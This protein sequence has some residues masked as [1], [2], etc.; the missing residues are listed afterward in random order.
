M[1]ARG[2]TNFVVHVP[3]TYDAHV[4]FH[5]V[6]LV[7]R[8]EKDDEIHAY[9]HKQAGSAGGL[10]EDLTATPRVLP[11][12]NKPKDK[13][14]EEEQER[15]DREVQKVKPG[16]ET[17][18]GLARDVIDRS[19]ERDTHKTGLRRDDRMASDERRSEKEEREQEDAKDSGTPSLER[20]A[21]SESHL[22][23]MKPAL[24]ASATPGVRDTALLQQMPLTA[25]DGMLPVISPISPGLLDAGQ[26]ARA[27]ALTP[28]SGLLGSPAA[29]AGGLSPLPMPAGPSALAPAPSWSIGDAGAAA[30]P[31]ASFGRPMGM[32]D[33][34]RSIFS[35]NNQGLEPAGRPALR[36]GGDDARKTTLPW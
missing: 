4:Q 6:S 33:S 35:Q 34:G 22:A 20:F 21:Q 5:Q 30:L 2:A 28:D 9:V 31:G 13:Q 36:S 15:K 29:G 11:R 14:K 32:Q 24:D 17:W 7:P 18:Q 1:G 23:G 12:T 27:G 10:P 25:G 19:V 8:E 3:R 26:M 16:M